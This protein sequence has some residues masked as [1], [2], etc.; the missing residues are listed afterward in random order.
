MLFGGF[1]GKALQDMNEFNLTVA[2]V[3]NGKKNG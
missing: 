1:V 2:E 3:I